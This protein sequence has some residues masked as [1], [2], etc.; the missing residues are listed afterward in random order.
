MEKFATAWFA[1]QLLDPKRTGG[2]LAAELDRIITG[3]ACSIGV[4]SNGTLSYINRGNAA[5]KEL[6][7]EFQ[8]LLRQLA[9]KDDPVINSDVPG[10]AL[11]ALRAPAG[12]GNV[13]DAVLLSG[14][15]E[16][17]RTAL[18]AIQEVIKEAEAILEERQPEEKEAQECPEL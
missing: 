7:A 4:V 18:M 10:M 14:P 6:E 3:P 11:Y 17:A 8:E 2:R 12:S 15:A 16:A 13:L 9:G 1:R 5:N